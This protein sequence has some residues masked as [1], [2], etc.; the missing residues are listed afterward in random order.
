M[1]KGRDKVNQF[2]LYSSESNSHKTLTKIT[3]VFMIL[4][5]TLLLISTLTTNNAFATHLSDDLKWQVVFISSNPGCGNYEYNMMNLY[6]DITANYLDLYDLNNLEYDPL[7]MSDK[8]YQSEYETP[9]DLDLIIL[10]Y[11]KNLGE[12][13]LH[14]NELGGFYAH[15]GIDRTRNHAIVLCDCSNFY[16][17]NPVWI[18]SHELSH[19]A[20]YYQDYE[21]DV[22]EKAIHSSDKRYDQCLEVYDEG[23]SRV[24]IKLNAVEGG[25]SYSVMPLY[26]PAIKNSGTSSTNSN[27]ISGAVL[28]L[29]KMITKWWS[30]DV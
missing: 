22:I 28:D 27:Q 20:L 19:F 23:C 13:E 7:C 17:S 12:S 25:Y 3:S 30:S 15:S 8:K 9:L 2:I 14:T 6:N 11:D 24:S 29:S 26:Q 21:M 16:Y 5:V 4:T 10:V 1:G 18:L